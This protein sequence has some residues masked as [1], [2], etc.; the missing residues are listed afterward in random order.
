MAKQISGVRRAWIADR[1]AA[2]LTADPRLDETGWIALNRPLNAG[3]MNPEPNSS[4]D[5][6]SRPMY[7]SSTLDKTFDFPDMQNYNQIKQDIQDTDAVGILCFEKADNTLEYVAGV[8]VD[9]R[10]VPSMDRASFNTLRISISATEVDQDAL[11]TTDFAA[12]A[13]A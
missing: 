6:M 13:L 1:A 3:D 4:P 7:A 5:G 8:E 11:V 10:I 9:V 12:T 2:G